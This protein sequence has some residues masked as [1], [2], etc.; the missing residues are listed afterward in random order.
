MYHFISLGG[1]QQS[2]LQL[3]FRQRQDLAQGHI[4]VLLPSGP[5]IYFGC[6][7]GSLKE[8]KVVF[9]FFTVSNMSGV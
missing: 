6:D 1:N 5:Q 9:S 2:L 3:Q 7:S 8:V 4:S